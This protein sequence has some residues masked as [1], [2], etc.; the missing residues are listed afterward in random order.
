MIFSTAYVYNLA[1]S[2]LNYQP[3][4]VVFLNSVERKFDEILWSVKKLSRE[5]CLTWLEMAWFQPCYSGIE[6]A[7]NYWAFLSK[8]Q[9]SRLLRH[10]HWTNELTWKIQKIQIRFETSWGTATDAFSMAENFKSRFRYSICFHFYSHYNPHLIRNRS[11]ILTI[12][13]ARIL[14]K[15]IP[16]RNVFGPRKV[17]KKVYKSWVIMARV[18]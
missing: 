17:E 10:L 9:K 3:N 4:V 18:R 1:Y 2:R 12:H 16:W 8:P 15:K 13:K 7:P 5:L 14:R 11:W 6:L